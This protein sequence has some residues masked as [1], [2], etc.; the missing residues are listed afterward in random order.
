MTSSQKE[1]FWHFALSLKNWGSPFFLPL[2]RGCG[3][4]NFPACNWKPSF[5][6]QNGPCT[7]SLNYIT[8][9]FMGLPLPLPITWSYLLA[10]VS[11]TDHPAILKNKK[12]HCKQIKLSLSDICFFIERECIEF[13]TV[14]TSSNTNLW[15]L[16]GVF[17]NVYIPPLGSVLLH[18]F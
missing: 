16:G 2:F 12:N 1:D 13:T 6:F 15:V 7:I 4:F 10:Y 8:I 11:Y 17:S 5:I 9:T 18:Y 3:I 14:S